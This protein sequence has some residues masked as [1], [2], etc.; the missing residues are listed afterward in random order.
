MRRRRWPIGLWLLGMACEVDSR[1]LS[2]ASPLDTPDNIEAAGGAGATAGESAASGL[3][4]SSTEQPPLP[5][6][7]AS[8]SA[9]IAPPPP[10]S[11]P[12]SAAGA[13]GATGAGSAAAGAAGS[14]VGAAGSAVGAA[15]SAAAAMGGMDPRPSP[16][17]TAELAGATYSQEC[18]ALQAYSV[19]FPLRSDPP[20]SAL[21]V[22]GPSLEFVDRPESEGCDWPDDAPLFTLAVGFRGIVTS[23]GSYIGAPVP[24]LYDLSDPMLANQLLI[25]LFV[26]SGENQNSLALYYSYDQLVDMTS[27]AALLPRQLEGLSGTLTVRE[28]STPSPATLHPVTYVIEVS[29]LVLRQSSDFISE[30]WPLLASVPRARLYW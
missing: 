15:G 23:Q 19:G 9:S 12:M 1:V 8:G 26:V 25:R 7:G 17:L 18:S 3:P 11:M 14:A 27:G 2:T 21:T 30:D 24:G 28:L 4:G 5:V 16:Y 29:E 10:T 13:G 6:L 20:G 22:W